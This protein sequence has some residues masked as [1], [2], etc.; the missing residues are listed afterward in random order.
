MSLSGGVVGSTLTFNVTGANAG[1]LVYIARSVTGIGDGPCLGAIGGACLSVTGEATLHGTLWTDADG[2]G[3]LVTSIPD[4]DALVLTEVCFQAVVR[5]GAGGSLSELATPGCVTLDR[6]SDGDGVP[7]ADDPCDSVDAATLEFPSSISTTSAATTLGAGGGGAMYTEGSF[8]NQDFPSTGTSIVTGLDMSFAMSNLTTGCALDAPE[9]YRFNVLLNGVLVGDYLMDAGSGDPTTFELSYSFP[10]LYGTGADVDDYSIEIV[11]Q[12]TVCSGGSSWNYY[13]GGITTL[14]ND[15]DCD[16]GT[17]GIGPEWFFGPYEGVG[18]VFD[19]SVQWNGTF[20]CEDE[21]TAIGRGAW[22]AR[23]VCNHWD[24]TTSEGCGPDN[25]GE[26]TS[27][28]C[29]EQI[30]DNVY[31]PGDNPACGGETQLRG[32]LLGSTGS[33]SY[34]WHALECQCF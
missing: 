1:D 11:A 13:P 12:S 20:R 3:T 22:G 26:W 32:F 29:T 6:D 28:W 4:L 5:R 8:I 14:R 18:T 27:E 10:P 34:T 7:D 30:I 23:W 21:C 15:G 2:A 19:P 25:H 9:I 31:I 33:E 24:G 17:G 16:D